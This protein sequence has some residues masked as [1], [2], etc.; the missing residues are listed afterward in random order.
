MVPGSASCASRLTMSA[1]IRAGEQGRRP[2]PGDPALGG[3][4]GGVAELL[5]RL[6]EATVGFGEIG[7]NVGR[8][9]LGR[10]AGDQARQ[11]RPDQEAVAR[12]ALAFVEQ[13]RPGKPAVFTLSQEEHGDGARNARRSAREDGLGE[14]QSRSIGAQEH[15]RRSAG[16]RGL[17]AVVGGDPPAA[18]VV[19]DHEGAAPEARALRLDQPQRRLHGHRRVHRRPPGP[20]HRQARLDGGRIGGGDHD[21]IGPG[22]ALWGLGGGLNADGEGA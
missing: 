1:A 16:R 4:V 11:A 21:L 6:D 22:G 2:L 17:A 8:L 18:G 9:G 10:A 14:R 19:V 13:R 5:A 15:V 12:Q 7:D 20:Q 3:G